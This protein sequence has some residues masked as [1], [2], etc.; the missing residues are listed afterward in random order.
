MLYWLPAPLI[1]V[2]ATLLLV[3]NTLF[4][5][6]PV[7]LLILVKVVTPKGRLRDAVSRGVAWSAQRWAVV[8]VKMTDAVMRV[9]W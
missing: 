6:V 5:V 7:Y 4:W 3:L 9:R 2:I 8:D 1:G